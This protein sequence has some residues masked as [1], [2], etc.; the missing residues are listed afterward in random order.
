M[1]ETTIQHVRRAARED[2][3]VAR[4]FCL[5]GQFAHHDWLKPK[6]TSIG[7]GGRTFS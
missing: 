6:T 7:A 5:G 4:N 2:R 3:G 1:I